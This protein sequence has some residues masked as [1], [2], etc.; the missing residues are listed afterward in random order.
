LVVWSHWPFEICP[1]YENSQPLML[2]KG[3]ATRCGSTVRLPRFHL[4]SGKPCAP[5][6]KK[7]N[8]PYARSLV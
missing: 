1:V 5:W 6:A 3:G 4:V 8:G 7:A 2:G